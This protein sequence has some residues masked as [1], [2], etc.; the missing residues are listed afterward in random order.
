MTCG[1]TSIFTY[2]DNPLKPESPLLRTPHNPTFCL[3]E[4]VSGLEGFPCI[5]KLDT[6][7][8]SLYTCIYDIRATLISYS[9]LFLSIE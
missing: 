8:K 9:V 5:Y 3:V 1:S 2:I 4:E 7:L 6:I